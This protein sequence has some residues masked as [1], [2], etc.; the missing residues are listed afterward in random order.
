MTK[1]EFIKAS[2]NIAKSHAGVLLPITEDK[3]VET[4][5]CNMFFYYELESSYDDNDDNEV[6]CTYWYSV[7]NYRDMGDPDN[8]IEF[9][10]GIDGRRGDHFIIDIKDWL[11]D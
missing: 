10:M 9:A 4:D 5:D 3:I 7:S 8:Q 6:M 11:Q 2:I 1:S